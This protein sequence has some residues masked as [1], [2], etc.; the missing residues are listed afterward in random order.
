M[1]NPNMGIMMNDIHQQRALMQ[2][3]DQARRPQKGTKHTNAVKK[4]FQKINSK[5]GATTRVLPDINS[6]R[7]MNKTQTVFNQNKFP[8][9]N[10]YVFSDGLQS[11]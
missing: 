6:K 8:M 7:Q 1:Q 10:D 9:R 5:K 3:S 11:N 2:T 4:Q